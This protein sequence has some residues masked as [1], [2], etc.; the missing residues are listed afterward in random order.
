MIFEI[1][2]F[3]EEDV[4]RML[5]WWCDAW[6]TDHERPKEADAKE[7]V[8]DFGEDVGTAYIRSTSW[9]YPGEVIP[10][11]FGDHATGYEAELKIGDRIEYVGNGAFIHRVKD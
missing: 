2:G 4:T 11:V 10:L 1:T 5:V 3:R 6:Y 7:M 9:G 8:D